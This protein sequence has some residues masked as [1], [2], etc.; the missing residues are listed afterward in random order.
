MRTSTAIP[1]QLNRV[2]LPIVGFEQKLE[3]KYESFM[4]SDVTAFEFIVEALVAHSASEIAVE[5]YGEK[6]NDRLLSY[7]PRTLRKRIKFIDADRSALKL[8]TIIFSP[9]FEEYHMKV[10]GHLLGLQN[11]AKEQLARA[12]LVDIFCSWTFLYPFLLG[13]KYKLEVDIGIEHFRKAVSTIRQ[14]SKNPESRANMSIL[15]GILGCYNLGEIEGLRIAPHAAKEQKESFIRFLEDLDY[16]ELSRA[17]FGLGLPLNFKKYS[18]RIRQLVRR[19]VSND[20]FSCMLEACSRPLMIATQVPM[21]SSDLV[22]TM[23]PSSYIPPIVNMEPALHQAR[24][25]WKRSVG[26]ETLAERRKWLEDILELH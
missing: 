26:D 19:I 22:K 12:L 13:L 9:I 17:N 24:E 21:P 1:L 20:K 15:E 14:K 5:S 23:V 2:Y 4:Y 7:L 8:A 11:I 6:I 3:S 18:I 16:E 25:A 10:D